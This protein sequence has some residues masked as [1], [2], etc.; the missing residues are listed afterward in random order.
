MTNDELIS[1]FERIEKSIE[2]IFD[3]MSKENIF[4]TEFSEKADKKYEEWSNIFQDSFSLINNKI[5]ILEDYAKFLEKE[6]I[7]AA[8]DDIIGFGKSLLEVS[9]NLNDLRINFQENI[10][11]IVQ[12]HNDLVNCMSNEFVVA[13]KR[14][15]NIERNK[16]D[17]E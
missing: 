2:F 4:I 11:K 15:E 10:D 16:N 1:R 9:D 5:D 14:I 3:L 17:K 7:N 6:K 8:F 13:H 12:K